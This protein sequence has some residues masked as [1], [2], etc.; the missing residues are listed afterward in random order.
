[1]KSDFGNK[2]NFSVP[3]FG[4]SAIARPISFQTPSPDDR[5]VPSSGSP[6]SAGYSAAWVLTARSSGLRFPVLPGDGCGLFCP[7]AGRRNSPGRP[8]QDF[9]GTTTERLFFR[10]SSDAANW[11]F[12]FTSNQDLSSHPCFNQREF[13]LKL[14]TVQDKRQVAFGESVPKQ[15]FA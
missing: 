4:D 12:F 1:M 14:F 6:A 10:M 8:L 7:A 9:H 13:P 5:R 2:G 15:A 11:S 3:D